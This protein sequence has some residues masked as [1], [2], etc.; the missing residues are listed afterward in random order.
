MQSNSVGVDLILRQKQT[1]IDKNI[2]LTCARGVYDQELAEHTLA[3]LLSLYRSVHLLRDDQT[4]V[5]WRRHRLLTLQGSECMIV[6]WG[7]LGKRIAALIR[8]FGGKVSGVRN[9]ASDSEDQG[10]TVYGKHTW[11][12]HLENVNALIIC[13]PKT[14][15][16][17][18][19]IGKNELQKLSKICIC[20]EH[21][22]RGH[23]GRSR[24]AATCSG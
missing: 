2:I 19:F 3:L 15:E 18:H 10:V 20:R 23:T 14:P 6:G 13:L 24:V 7:S 16:T 11:Q 1:L 9:Q 21:W 12:N 17:Y 8:A 5:Q 4:A 22:A